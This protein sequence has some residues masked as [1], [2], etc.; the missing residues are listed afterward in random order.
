[1]HADPGV[2]QELRAGLEAEEA[3]YRRAR[4]EFQEHME[5]RREQQRVKLEL[6]DAKAKLQLARKEQR[7]MEAVVT[8]MVAVKVFSLE[9]LGKGK[10]KG[11][12]QQHQKARLEVLERLRR[13][14]ELSP[15]QTTSWEL[16]KKTWDTEM[17]EAH[18]EDWAELFAQLVQNVLNDLP[19]GRS[20][21]LS[22][23]VHNETRRVLSDTPAL[24]AP[25][26]A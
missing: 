20:N 9:M 14:A 19:E 24:L 25:G 4:I 5:R 22:E 8:A 2:C 17:A 11:G 23:F 12:N 6:K 18:E 21:A 3:S 26:A 16:F 13:C 7:S 1:M 10:K 15:A